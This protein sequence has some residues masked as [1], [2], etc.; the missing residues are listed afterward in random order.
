MQ[1]QDVILDF[2]GQKVAG[3]KELQGIVERLEVGKTYTMTV[4]RDG[5]HLSLP[6]TVEAMPKR[7][8]TL[9]RD[10]EEN[11]SANEKPRETVA[12]DDLG[13]EISALTP[14]AAKELKMNDAKGVV[15]SSVKQG[16]LADEAGLR[17]GM[18]IERINK[19]AVT[20]PEEFRDA[21]KKASLLKGIILDVRTPAGPQLL[22]IR[23][24]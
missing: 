3:T 12:V 16:S 4:I 1:S 11:G 24:G 22:A 15:V 23:K 6:V 5:K 21:M 14:E 10:E 17:D 19:H 13:I 8:S 20:T 18:V 7:E 9:A 2:N